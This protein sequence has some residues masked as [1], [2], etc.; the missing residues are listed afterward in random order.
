MTKEILGFGGKMLNSLW[1]MV[2]VTGLRDRQK[3]TAPE[4][5][6]RSGSQSTGLPRGP[7]A[8]GNCSLRSMRAP[9]PLYK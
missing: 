8:H 3:E 5:H 6:E 4:V 9:A 2:R 1:N 7:R